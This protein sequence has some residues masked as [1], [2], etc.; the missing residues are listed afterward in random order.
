MKYKIITNVECVKASV[1]YLSLESRLFETS[2][3]SNQK[4]FHFTSQSTQFLERSF[5]FAKVRRFVCATY[6][7]NEMGI[8]LGPRSGL[9]L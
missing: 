5:I 8:I 7:L 2:D 9:K 1:K 3:N 4:P 6:P